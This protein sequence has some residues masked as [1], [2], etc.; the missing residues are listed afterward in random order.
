M[1]RLRIR[2]TTLR[3]LD[4]LVRQRRGMFESMQSFSPEEH[5]VGDREYRRW[6]KRLMSKR[7]FVG[8]IAETAAGRPV[9]G[10]A[11]WLREHLPRP[12]KAAQKI[13]YLISMYTEPEFRGRGLASRI[14]K[15]AMHWSQRNGHAVMTLHASKQ[16]RRVYSR[17]HWER[18]WEMRVRLR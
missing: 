8:W 1:S 11:V 18:T 9:A 16:G 13:P 5:A 15:E 10:G 3:D 2:R 17:L 6:A 4:V 14:V 12:G 7:G